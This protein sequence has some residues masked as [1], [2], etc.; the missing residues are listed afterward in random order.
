M[1][2]VDEPVSDVLKSQ[3]KNMPMYRLT[4]KQKKDSRSEAVTPLKIQTSEMELQK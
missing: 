4:L 2:N 3:R 1:V